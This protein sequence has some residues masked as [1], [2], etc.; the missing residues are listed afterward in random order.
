MTKN[1]DSK[2]LSVVHPVCCGLDVHKKIIV[3]TLILTDSSGSEDSFTKEFGTFTD[4]LEQLREWLSEHECPV[5]AM[6]STGIYWRCVH[7]IPEADFEVIPVNARHVKNVP[8]RKTDIEDSRWLAGLLRHGLLRGSFI[9]PKEIR[10]WR[11]L[12][13]LRRK[14]RD[15][16]SD[17]K[18]RVHKLFESANIKIDSVASDLFGVTGQNLITL[19]MTGPEDI[20]LEDIEHCARG[21]LRDKVAELHRGIQGFFEE[22]HRFQ[23]TGLMHVI[24]ALEQENES[25]D[26]RMRKLMQEH[27]DL[28]RRLDEVPGIGELSAQY[29]LS[30]LGPEL[31]TFPHAAA[32]AS[33]AGLCPGNNESAGKRH[34]GRSPVKK[35]PLKTVMLEVARAAVKKKGTYY[36]DKY[37]RL[38]YRLGPEKAI[39]A[40]AH[41]IIKALFFIIKEG[42]EYRE[43]GEDYLQ[44]KNKKS[45]VIKIRRKA[46]EL[47]FKL[48]PIAV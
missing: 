4:E 1:N 38:R 42:Q 26:A 39:I 5:V 40:I 36:R 25:I 37:W 12:S 45:K 23:L 17:Y 2:I 15:T 46:K 24:A 44:K 18:R 43:P 6:E 21:S 41:R 28:I 10:Q 31:D 20:S 19:L 35:H 9:P 29:I 11:E 47:G 3:A 16:L 33:R 34:S 14:N 22:H 32:L 27:N 48:V 13:R 7:N 30:E 8:G